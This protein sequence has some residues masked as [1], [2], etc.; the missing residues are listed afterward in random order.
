MGY[1]EPILTSTRLTPESE[2]SEVWSEVRDLAPD[3]PLLF[4]GHE[5]LFSATASW[6]TGETHVII[7]FKP[8]T[9]ARI[10]FDE[11]S[12]EPRGALRWKIPR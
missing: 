4:V 6:M 9:M 5:P 7:E 2:P 11:V 3:S 10:D 12:V 8:A 1:D